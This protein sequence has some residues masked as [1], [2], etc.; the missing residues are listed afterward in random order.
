MNVE[1]GSD[2]LWREIEA[3]TVKVRK[4]LTLEA[5]TAV[6]IIKESRDAYKALGKEPS[7]YRLS[8]EAL[9]RRILQGKSVIPDQ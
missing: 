8:S 3:A 1:P 6:N 9:L 5:L 2:A 7:R 4:E